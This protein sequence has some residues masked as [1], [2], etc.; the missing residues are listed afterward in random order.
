M[1]V[2]SMRLEKQRENLLRRLWILK[3][4]QRIVLKTT[5]HGLGDLFVT[6]HHGYSFFWVCCA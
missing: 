3:Q 4:T 6:F 1:K 2:I 5:F